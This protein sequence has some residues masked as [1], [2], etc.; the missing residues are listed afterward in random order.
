MTKKQE[1]I[2]AF[3][4]QIN[5]LKAHAPFELEIINDFQQAILCLQ[6]KPFNC[7]AG[8]VT[9]HTINDFDSTYENYVTN[10]EIRTPDENLFEEYHNE[11]F[12]TVLFLKGLPAS[13]KTTYAKNL[14]R[15][16]KGEVARISKDEIRQML[17]NGA[18]R[19]TNERTVNK[20]IAKTAKILHDN[21]YSLIII[22]ACNMRSHVDLFKQN[23]I[24]GG[25]EFEFILQTK[26]FNTPEHICIERDKN[27]GK[28]GGKFVG[29]DVIKTMN[30]RY[31]NEDKMS[32]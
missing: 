32:F 24:L 5:D 22:D 17:F 23:L 3:K 6:N 25:D 31:F 30:E 26:I 4:T 7:N 14:V 28:Q 18:Y 21:F 19:P 27:R 16:S 20:V 13:G 29:E 11:H 10:K 12:T 9:A 8:F 1:L 15:Y 2:S